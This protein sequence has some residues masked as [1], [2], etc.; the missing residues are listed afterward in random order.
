MRR[1]PSRELL[2][3]DAGTPREIADS[4]AD[5]RFINRYFGGV[6]T[7]VDM[8]KRI[9]R[10]TGASRFSMLDAAAGSGDMAEAVR[11][12]LQRAGVNLQLT[13]LDRMATHMGPGENRV[14]GDALA[15]PFR[16]GAFDLVS[17]CLFVHHLAPAQ[18]REFVK[19]A[20]RCGRVAVLINDLIRDPV[21]LAT[22]Q[23]G[24]FIY[25]SRITVNDSAASV[26]QAYTVEEMRRMLGLSGSA[27]VEISRHYFYRMGAIVWKAGPRVT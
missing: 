6:S 3:D 22:A 7:T 11:A 19:E 16:D 18:V 21:H 25:R 14:Q 1:V 15:L 4:L 2:D 23:L 12:R 26:R 10:E 20:L 17:C 5:V 27:R 13:M 9:A 8:L 24:R